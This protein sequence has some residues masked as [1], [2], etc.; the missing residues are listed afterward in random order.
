MVDLR[1]L[2]R[3]PPPCYFSCYFSSY[4]PAYCPTCCPGYCPDYCPGYCSGYSPAYCPGQPLQ[5]LPR[6][7]IALAVALTA[8]PR[9]PSPT[10]TCRP[11]CPSFASSSSRRAFGQT[12]SL[13][14]PALT[15]PLPL[16][17]PLLLLGRGERGW[18]RGAWMVPQG[19]RPGGGRI[20]WDR[21]ASRAW[22]SWGT[23]SAAPATGTRSSER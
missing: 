22:G 2:R 8:G 18:G 10:G 4:C 15:L 23:S 16:P 20:V 13:L 11:T 1:I 7:C 6:L 9:F 5:L 19:R 21:F 12:L 3:P 14:P 17:L